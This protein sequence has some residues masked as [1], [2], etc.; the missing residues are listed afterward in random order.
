MHR[1]QCRLI[2]AATPGKVNA[3][4]R[5]PM[6]TMSMA[7]LG[8]DIQLVDA[9]AV[10]H[11]REAMHRRPD[12]QGVRIN[13]IPHRRGAAVHVSQNLAQDIER[14]D[15]IAHEGRVLCGISGQ[16]VPNIR[17]YSSG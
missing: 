15:G 7:W 13:L 10:Y 16:G 17:R 11:T 12:E 8:F 2:R 9:V 3:L 1:S 5:V 4:V 14:V 6:T